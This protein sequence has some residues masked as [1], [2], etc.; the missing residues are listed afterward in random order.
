M[1]L[2]DDRN[3]LVE[4]RNELEV[5]DKNSSVDAQ[6][7]EKCMKTSLSI[8]GESTSQKNYSCKQLSNEKIK[9]L[10]KQKAGIIHVDSKLLLPLI[11]RLEMI[12][13]STGK[14]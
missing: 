10:P 4:Q 11:P 8:E 5:S 6:S 2:F 14:I 13:N 7:K 12:A 3:V 9:L 1:I